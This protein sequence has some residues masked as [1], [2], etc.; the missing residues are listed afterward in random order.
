MNTTFSLSFLTL[1]VYTI[2]RSKNYGL[3]S[4]VIKKAIM[5]YTCVHYFDN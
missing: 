4:E 5:N 3:L 2:A 1:H